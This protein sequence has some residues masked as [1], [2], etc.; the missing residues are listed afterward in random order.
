MYNLTST[1]DE[2]DEEELYKPQQHSTAISHSTQLHSHINYFP[3]C[4]LPK[5]DQKGTDH[6]HIL[7][8]Q[9][10]ILDCT[11]KYLYCQGGVGSAKSLAFAIKCIYLSLTIPKNRG[12][13]SRL[14]YDDLFDSSWR[15]INECIDRLIDKELLSSVERT[16]KVQGEYTQITLPNGS[17]IKAVQAKNWQRALG[18]N[19]GWFWIDDA[20]EVEREFFVGTNTSAG[21]LSRLRLPHIHFDQATYAEQTRQH[22]SLHGM[23]SSNPPP[24]GSWLH[25]LFGDTPGIHTLGDDQVTWME[26]STDANPFVG[27]DYAKGLTAVQRKMGGTQQT[28]NRI[29]HGKSIPAYTGVAVF[30]QFSHSQ[31]VAP[32]KFRNDLPLIR[33]WDFG[34]IH[35]AV[36]FS[37]LHKCTYGTNHYFT[38][39]EVCEVHNTTIYNF[40]DKYVLPHTNALYRNA[41]LIRD[42]GD[43]SGYRHS[44]SNKDGRSDMKILMDEYHLPFRWKYI[45]L[46]PSLQYMRSLLQPKEPCRCGL[47]HILIS[48]KCKNLIGALEG[49]YHFAKPRNSVQS[50]KPIEDRRFADVACAWR[51]GA[52]NYVKW[53]MSYEE[54]QQLHQT[55]QR[56]HHQQ[57]LETTMHR[58][59]NAAD[60][61]A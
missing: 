48:N 3:Q 28:I 46:E 10:T 43:R 9:Q 20:M 54:K 29:L 55:P 49:G 59:L 37:N 6:A 61:P 35:P 24:Y 16:K 41:T 45:N 32:L 40:Y 5:C 53:G 51:Y 21:L 36:V 1:I 39:S 44:S 18:A 25:E 34:S 52:E 11:T 47:P 30:P 15:E 42:C 57:T 22:G 17:E 27:T 33:S 14:H 38:L 13:V 31:H 60:L 26:V 23:V 19:H 4:L 50:D 8:H 56:F 7:P 2:I 12:V 58:W